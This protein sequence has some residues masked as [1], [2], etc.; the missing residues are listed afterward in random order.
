MVL[1]AGPPGPQCLP[2]CH[3]RIS[4]DGV[5]DFCSH[6]G[7]LVEVLKVRLLRD[8]LFGKSFEVV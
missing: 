4:C 1:L 8:T 7:I 2:R 5:S 6:C 3:G